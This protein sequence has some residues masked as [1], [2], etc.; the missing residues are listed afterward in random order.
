MYKS[1]VAFS[2]LISTFVA[3]PAL[4][5]VVVRPSTAG[6]A[7]FTTFTVAVPS[8]KELATTGLKILIPEGFDF[9][10]PNVKPGWNITTNKS[11]EKITEISWNGGT[12]PPHQRDEFVFSAKT[13]AT[14]T[15]LV[16]KAYQTYA[17]GSVVAWDQENEGGHQ[18]DFTASGP[19]SHTE[20]I[21]DLK[22]DEA[23]SQNNYLP[24]ALS[25]VALALSGIAVLKKR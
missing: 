8:E 20:I 12:I 18:T 5:H 16:W 17:D 9:V 4:A 14:P 11:E 25:V 10:T 7:Q 22:T 23:K 15:T 3:L 2:V 24:L 6:I 1:I 13:P 19:A 21:D